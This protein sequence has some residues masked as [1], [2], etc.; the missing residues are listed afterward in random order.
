MKNPIG[1]TVAMTALALSLSGCGEAPQSKEKA[2]LNVDVVEIGDDS[3]GSELHFPAIAAAAD[4]AEL[5]FLVAGEINKIN[6]KAGDI[7]KKDTVLA[8]LDPTDYKLQVDNAKARFDVV[9]SQYRRSKPLVD[10]G[11]LAKS[12]FDEIGAQRAIAKAELELAKLKLSY[13][14][15]KAPVDGVISRVPVQQFENVGI[16]QSIL[17]IHDA[18]QVDIRIQVPDV[19][20]SKH[21]G[22][23]REENNATIRPHVRT[24]DGKEYRA[25]VKEFTAQPDPE[26]GSFMVTLTMPMPEDKFILDGMTVEVVVEELGLYNDRAS[27]VEIPMETVFNEDGDAL[28]PSNKFVWVVGAD[29]TV[30]KRKVKVGELTPTGVLVTN[31]LERGDKVVSEGV[32]RLRAG[33]SVNIVANKEIN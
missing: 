5:S 23:T 1:L 12:Q 15:L 20:F 3:L 27:Q 26:T 21:G 2:L 33:Q 16:G 31:G 8:T 4:R 11:L 28:D 6:V 10:K 18:T 24:E 25:S 7:V 19:L 32:N 22:K 30:E 9:D 17:N 29:N 14:E 13:T